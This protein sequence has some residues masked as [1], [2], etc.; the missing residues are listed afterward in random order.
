MKTKLQILVSIASLLAFTEVSNAKVVSLNDSHINA[1]LNT[2]STLKVGNDLNIA[3]I[4]R[5]NVI[6]NA[7][8]STSTSAPDKTQVDLS[9]LS[10]DSYHHG[11]GSSGS[12]ER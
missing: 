11:G 2:P 1:I 5:S 9:D 8:N 4:S 7:D 12:S 6:L 3:D 10:V